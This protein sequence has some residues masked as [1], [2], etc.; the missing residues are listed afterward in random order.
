M[1]W[2][3]AL[4]AYNEALVLEKNVNKLVDF[5]QKNLKPTNWQIV[6]VDNA[7]TDQTAEVGK[8][9]AARYENVDY[10][11]VSQKGKGAAIRAAWVSQTADIYCFMDADL[12]TD[13]SALPRLV[14]AMA[15]GAEVVIGSR[16][17]PQSQV[18]RSMIRWLVSWGYRL[19]LKILL[20]TKIN[21]APCG[22][23]A[24]NQAVKTAIL[25]LVQNKEWFFDSELVI[26]AEKKGYW[27]QEIPVIW[28]D[29][30][31]GKDKSRV[32]IFSLGRDYLKQIFALRQRLKSL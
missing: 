18:K 7:S 16:F 3:I 30:R 23:K 5:C 12:A 11:F 13:L 25:P 31:E 19:A 17:Q 22:F 20:K 4:P 6:I 2:L 32:K 29:P 21:D 9:L 15:G 14:Q 24:I 1:K 8:R 28:A 26:L 10:I 27:V